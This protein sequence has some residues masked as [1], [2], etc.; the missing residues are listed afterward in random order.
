MENNTVGTVPTNNKEAEATAEQKAWD[1]LARLT[2]GSG[3]AVNWKW[4]IPANPDRDSDLI[5][6]AGLKAVANER[7]ALAAILAAR[8]PPVSVDNLKAAAIEAERIITEEM[9][10]EAIT[11]A[12]PFKVGFVEGAEWQAS[13]PREVE[14]T[15]EAFAVFV[16]SFNGDEAGDIDD[17][18]AL[19]GA[20]GWAMRGGND[21]RAVFEKAAAALG[22]GE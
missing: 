7:D 14:V 22:G 17:V 4:S 6:A 18:G 15:D 19:D 21:V 16:Q 3:P 5:L 8:R 11:G 13:Q 20:T 9:S 12:L 2:S 1:E 10:A